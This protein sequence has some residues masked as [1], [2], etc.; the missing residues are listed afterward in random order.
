MFSDGLS[1]LIASGHPPGTGRRVPRFQA[2]GSHAKVPLHFLTHNDAIAGFTSQSLDL[3]AYACK[4]DSCSTAIKSAPRMHQDLPF[5]VKKS[6]N[7]SG[8]A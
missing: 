1:L 4:T 6:L 8:G 2:G 5:R 7:N 3:P